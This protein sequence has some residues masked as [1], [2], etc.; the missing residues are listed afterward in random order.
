LAGLFTVG[1]VI[2]GRLLIRWQTAALPGIQHQEALLARQWASRL[3]GLPGE[4]PAA[5]RLLQARQI[6]RGVAGSVILPGRGIGWRLAR[7]FR[8]RRNAGLVWNGW[9]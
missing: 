4:P 8:L 9:A 5:P 2:S 1:G 7:D 6:W 3:L